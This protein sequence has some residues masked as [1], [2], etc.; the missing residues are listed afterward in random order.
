MIKCRNPGIKMAVNFNQTVLRLVKKI[1]KGKV[2]TYKI[3]AEQTSK[4]KAYR[5]VGR[6]LNSNQHLI[7]VPCHRV[8][9]SD[10]SLGGYRLGL[11]KKKAIL[12]REGIV[13]HGDRIKNF[14][15]ALFKFKS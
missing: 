6:A 11:K 10:G 3:L 12:A 9:K 13:L 4:R 5:L 14:N 2:T 1:P 7:E 8:V 15:Q